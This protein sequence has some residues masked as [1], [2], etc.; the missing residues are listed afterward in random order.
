MVENY[1]GA[2]EYSISAH[3]LFLCM[4]Q[5]VSAARQ[6]DASAG[7]IDL[8]EDAVAKIVHCDWQA[9]DVGGVVSW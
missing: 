1:T 2:G 9:H 6:A 4:S 8:L 7:T 3:D 5:V